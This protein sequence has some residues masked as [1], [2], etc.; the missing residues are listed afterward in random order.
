MRVR[1][2]RNSRTRAT[3]KRR[4]ACRKSRRSSTDKVVD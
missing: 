4:K 2:W 3:E 1:G